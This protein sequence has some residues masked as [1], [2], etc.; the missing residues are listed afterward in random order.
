M[1]WGMGT[2]AKTAWKTL[3]MEM[4]QRLADHQTKRTTD[5][6]Y[7]VYTRAQATKNE[8]LIM[9]YF[10]SEVSFASMIKICK[11]MKDK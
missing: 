3:N 8:L 7:E 2:D 11:R 1:L 10:V 6:H 4:H 5:Q 9:I